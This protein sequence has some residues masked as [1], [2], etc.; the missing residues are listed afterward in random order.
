MSEPGSG[1]IVTFLFTSIEGSSHL[2]EQHSNQL[3]T[4]LADHNALLRG[5]IEQNNGYIFKTPSDAFCAAFTTATAALKAAYSA[6][7]ALTTTQWEPEI[8]PLKVRMALHTGVVE[9]RDGHY[10]GQALK[11]V[12]GLGSIG[13]SPVFFAPVAFFEST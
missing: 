4:V 11:R 8:G 1:D 2:W 5:F 7:L 10:F 13:P 9:M 12:A 6:Q 3:P